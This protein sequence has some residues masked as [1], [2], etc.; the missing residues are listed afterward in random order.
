M[1]SNFKYKRIDTYITKKFLGTF[2]YSIALIIIIVII[3]DISEKIDDF[4]EKNAPLSEIIFTYY[5]NFVPYFV[6]LFSPLFTFIAVIYFTS[7]LANNTEIIAVLSSGISYYRLLRPFIYSAVFLALFSFVLSNFIIPAANKK[8]ISF[9]MKYIKNPL[10]SKDVNIHMQIS[11]GGYAYAEHFNSH[12]NTAY[13]FSLERI[14]EKGLVY[15]I[16]S[17]IA[18]WDSTTGSWKIENYYVRTI[19]SLKET[20][21]YS[22]R[23]D[24]TINL[25]PSDFIENLNNIATMNWGELNKYIANEKLKGSDYVSHY[26]M[27]KHRRIASP[28]ATVVL[29]LIGVSLSSRKLRGG[30]GL[31]LGFGIA[32]SFSFI[33]FMQ[34]SSTFATSGNL[35]PVIAAWIP[36]IIFGA[37][38]IY[39]LRIAPK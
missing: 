19:D 39:L 23:L 15:K 12:T 5:L 21:S 4:L 34:I 29:T 37:L 25:K 26:L 13:N 38:G 8:R 3:F 28:F 31:H 16:N 32:L 11:P 22:S 17:E 7:K 24:T 14:T 6:N 2:F 33:M 10:R 27:E 20:L 30:I 18:K 36:N 1:F 9:E 35:P